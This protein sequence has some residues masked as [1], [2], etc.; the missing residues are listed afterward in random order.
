METVAKRVDRLEEIMAELAEQSKITQSEVARLSSETRTFKDDMNKKW[1]DLARKMG[2]LVEDIFIPSF[3]IVLEKYFNVIPKKVISRM[4]LR[5]KDRVLELD[6]L[7]Y[8]DD[9]AFIVEVKSSPDRP[10]YVDDFIEKLKILP[11]FLP[12]IKSYKVIP[13]YAGLTMSENTIK[14]LTKNNIYAL[15]VKGDILEIAN[16]GKI[17]V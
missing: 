2:T 7:G 8:T 17:K 10:G 6:I 4:R 9:K 12:E 15:I 3:D 13:I 16:F 11:E 14:H 1:G 5:D